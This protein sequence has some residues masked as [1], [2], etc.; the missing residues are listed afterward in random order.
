LLVRLT[1]GPCPRCPRSKRPA[2]SCRASCAGAAS[3][4]RT[5]WPTPS[6]PPG[7]SRGDGG[8][9]GRPRFWKL[10]TLVSTGKSLAFADA[11]R[12][13]RI[14]LQQHPEAE[15]PIAALGFDAL[16]GVPPAAELARVLARRQAP[17]K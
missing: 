16:L 11:R 13:G 2:S 5:P 8:T 14:R 15:P 1:L 9:E 12:F 4:R 6:S 7:A 17:I 10:Q 3:K